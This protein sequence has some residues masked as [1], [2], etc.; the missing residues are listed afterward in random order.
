MPCEI[1]KPL[2]KRVGY[3]TLTSHE[4]IF[5]DELSEKSEIDSNNNNI[6]FFK[7]N[8]KP[9]SLM[10][11][12]IPLPDIKELQRRRFLGR[13]SA[14]EIQLMNGKSLMLNFANIEDRDTFG[15]KIVR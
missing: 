9:N 4:I 6:F 15:K 14:L 10:Y 8:K 5:F 11:K 12:V 13:K 1:L 3:C 7:Y 2:Y